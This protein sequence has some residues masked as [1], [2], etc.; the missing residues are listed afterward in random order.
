ESIVYENSMDRMTGRDL[1]F[2]CFYGKVGLILEIIRYPEIRH[3]WWTRDFKR[4]TTGKYDES[5]FSGDAVSP[6]ELQMIEQLS[7]EIP[8]PF[9]RIDF[10]QSENGLVFGEFTPKPGNYDDFDLK[11]DQLLGDYYIEAEARLIKD[12]LK[13]KTFPEYEQF[14]QSLKK[15]KREPKINA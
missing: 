4:V 7:E 13:G 3:C 2:Y 9:V 1:K 14:V 15:E 5:L 10:L 6:E 12:L 11:T 8:A